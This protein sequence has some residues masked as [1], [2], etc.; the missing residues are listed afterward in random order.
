M[1]KWQIVF[2]KK[3]KAVEKINETV[4][5]YVDYPVPCNLTDCQKSRIVLKTDSAVEGYSIYAKD[6]E[7]IITAKDEINLLYAASDFKNKFI[8]Y[9]KNPGNKQ[10]HYNLPFVDDMPSFSVCETPKIKKRG[11]WTWGHVIYD[12]KKFID[13]MVILRLNTLIIWNDFIPVNIADIIEYAH[14]YGIKVILGYSWGWKEIGNK[15]EVITDKHIED[16]KKLVIDEYRENYVATNCDGIYFQSF[17]EREEESVG[18]KLIAEMVTD[19]VNEIAEELWK[20]TPDLR[21][22]FGLHASSVKNRLNEIAKVDKRIEILWEDCGQYPFSY[23]SYV[24]DEEKYRETTEFIGRLLELRGGAGVGFAFKGLMMLDWNR[25]KNQHGPFIMGE[26][27]KEIAEHDKRMRANAWRIYSANWM[28]H[29]EAA[30]EM[31]RYINE[32][33]T[34]EVNMCV[35][36]TFDGGIYLPFAIYAQCFR[37]MEESYRNILKKVARRDCITVD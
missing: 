18:G 22:I 15:V 29:G 12:Y 23:R 25:F 32:H 28:Q 34:S 16:V 24:E 20:I 6:S 9:W 10:A 2:D 17:T 35:A 26:N 5:Q 37:K 8:P 36:G 1:N 14:S 30:A 31:F 19:M 7:I 27:S 3:C 13:N 33:K 4:S 11:I 21:L